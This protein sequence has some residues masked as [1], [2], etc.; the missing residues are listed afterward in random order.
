MSRDITMVELRG[1]E[2]L[3]PSVAN[4]VW[5]IAIRS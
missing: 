1:L 2:P 3:T 5:G 4:S